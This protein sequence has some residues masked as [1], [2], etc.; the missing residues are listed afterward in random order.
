MR[1]HTEMDRGREVKPATRTVEQFFTEWLA[2]VR[3]SLKP[4][5]YANYSTNVS[6][7]ILP[8]I[9]K[10]KLRDVTVPVLNAHRSTGRDRD[11]AELIGRVISAALSGSAG[12]A[13]ETC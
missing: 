8:K 6:A 13:P 4:S 10:R 5:A 9:G 3:H 7:Y 1:K 11:A 12:A 2:G